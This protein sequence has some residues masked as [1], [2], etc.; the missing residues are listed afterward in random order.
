MPKTTKKKTV[1]KMRQRSKRR[2]KKKKTQKT[3][4]QGIKRPKKWI[5]GIKYG[6]E[7]DYNDFMSLSSKE[8]YDKVIIL[9]LTGY[10]LTK[11][12]ESIGK[13]SQLQVLRCSDNQLTS[14]PETL[15]NCSQLEYLYCINNQMTELPK[16]LGN[17]SK[18]I[19]LDCSDNQ[20]SQLPDS[21][22]NCNQLEI[23]KCFNNHLTYLPETL[24]NCIQLKILECYG[25][26]INNV[27]ISPFKQLYDF[28]PDIKTKFKMTKELAINNWIADDSYELYKVINDILINNKNPTLIY[29]KNIPISVFID[30]LKENMVPFK[31][32]NLN[33]KIVYRGGTNI[34][35][36]E[37][38][39]SKPTFVSV[40]LEKNVA[41]RFAD[42]F[43][44]CCLYEYEINDNVLVLNL[45]NDNS[46]EMELLIHPNSYFEYINKT[47][48][49]GPTTYH[50]T[51]YSHLYKKDCIKYNDLGM[52]KKM[53]LV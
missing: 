1:N 35:G 23:L 26:N 47:T 16:T 46:D 15:G 5:G 14:L 12:P 52:C 17:C 20:L 24:T 29:H 40:S 18:L 34:F 42:P 36:L 27:D 13:C 43:K 10:N 32:L 44:G 2:T 33:K 25:N 39:F 28:Y 4:K 37:K 6:C 9:E 48:D 38:S 11:L 45:S 22:G 31:D 41:E 30:T 50:Y 8:D 19:D 7:Y 21:L 49:N 53:D 51:V 3:K